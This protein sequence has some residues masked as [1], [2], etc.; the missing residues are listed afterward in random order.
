MSRRFAVV[1]ILAAASFLLS[2]A[3]AS[4]EGDAVALNEQA[5]LKLEQKEYDAAIEL[6]ERAVA[7]DPED[8]TIRKNLAVAH[9]NRGLRLLDAFE[10]GRSVRDFDRAVK[11][12]AGEPLFRVHLGYAYLKQFDFARAEAVLEDTRRSF[13]AEPRAYDYLGFLHYSDDELEK[14]IAIWEQRLALA[15]DVDSKW[16]SEMLSKARREFEVS[17]DFVLRTNNDFVLKLVGDEKNEAAAAAILAEL[18]SARAR[19]GSDLSW[20]P[21]R[22]TI[23]LLYTTEEFR[24]ATGSHEWVGGLYDGKIRLQVCD[25]ERQ[26]E[27]LFETIRHEYTHRVLAEMA[28]D[29]PIWMNEGLAEWY[30]NGGQRAHDA[31]RAAQR[32][33]AEVPA[34]SGLPASFAGQHDAAVVRVQYAASYSF[35][36]FLRDRYGIAALREILLGLRR[37]LTVDEAMTRVI[38]G[39]VPAM[40][41]L[42]RREILS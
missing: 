28:P 9:N 32:D 35:M 41:A 25:F 42:W 11:L 27:A 37:G 14:A 36:T 17:S 31:I 3:R 2:V 5:L 23:V 33:G 16:T 4:G 7:A 34:F 8:A 19:I 38:G 10:F 22:R 29:V 13:P 26:K 18:E 1:S 20:F 24:R 39:D 6:L 15:T 40:E 30:G 12:A 21:Q